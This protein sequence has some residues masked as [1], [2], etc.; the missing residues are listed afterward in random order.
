VRRQVFDRDGGRCTHVDPRG[1]RCRETSL[2]ELHHREPHA[3]GGPDSAENLT[4]RC[5]AH[6]ALAAERDFGLRNQSTAQ[7]VS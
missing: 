4:L 1:Q 7:T 3:R 5:R 2:L 6:N